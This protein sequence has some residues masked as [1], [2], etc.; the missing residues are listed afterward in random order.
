MVDFKAQNPNLLPEGSKFS[1]ISD[2]KWN[3]TKL[4]RS[5]VK[6]FFFLFL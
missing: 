3:L 6:V 4:K 5:A 2:S 1:L